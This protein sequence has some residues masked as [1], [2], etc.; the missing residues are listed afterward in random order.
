MG[1]WLK[2]IYFYSYILFI[3]YLCIF[4]CIGKVRECTNMFIILWKGIQEDEEHI[5]LVSCHE[6]QVRF[7]VFVL[8]WEPLDKEGPLE[9]REASEDAK[10]GVFE[11]F[12]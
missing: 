7:E 10:D 4:R 9:G 11:C 5:H 3:S 2:M 8:E 1:N 12:G 6:V